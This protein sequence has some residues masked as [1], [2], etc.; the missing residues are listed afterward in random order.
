MVGMAWSGKGALSETKCQDLT[1][2]GIEYCGKYKPG[3]VFFTGKNLK[4]LQQMGSWTHFGR[5]KQIYW[6]DRRCYAS[7]MAKNIHL[8]YEA[9]VRLHLGWYAL[10]WVQWGE[11]CA[12]EVRLQ[13]EQGGWSEVCWMWPQG[14][15]RRSVREHDPQ[16]SDLYREATQRK[17]NL[18][19]TVCPW[20]KK[21]EIKSGVNKIRLKSIAWEYGLLRISEGWGISGWDNFYG[22]V[23]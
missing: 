23:G 10:C 20:H 18:L 16:A 9:L 3:N 1:L 15:S 5:K 21:K 22:R 14:R 4:G 2:G 11:S 6:G 12:R 8:F 7:E 13:R 17:G 19:L